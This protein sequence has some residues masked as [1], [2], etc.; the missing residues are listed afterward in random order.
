MHTW[1]FPKP[2]H[3]SV[4]ASNIPCGTCGV[5][6]VGVR[7]HQCRGTSL[8]RKRTPLA[9]Y[10]RPMPRVLGR[11]WEGGRFLM[12]EVPLYTSQVSRGRIRSY[13]RALQGHLAHENTHPHRIT[14][15]P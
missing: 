6:G 2:P 5:W 8:T 11:S 4:S 14:I 12:G 9:P 1:D 13:R 10:R 3:T 7:D 15:G